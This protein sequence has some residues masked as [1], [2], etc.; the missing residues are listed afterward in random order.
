[1][2]KFTRSCRALP[3]I[4]LGA[5]AAMPAVAQQSNAAELEELRA[6]V[7]ALETERRTPLSFGAAGGT[8][9]NIYGFV[10][11]EFF[12]DPDFEFGDL[13]VAGDIPNENPDAQAF[14]SS[15]RVS[16]LGVRSSTPSA[17]GDI[18]TQLEYD[19]FGGEG[20]AELRL[21][22]ANVTIGD[23]LLFG[24]FWTNF[25][26]LS[27]YP[28]TADFNGP[29]GITFARVPQVRYS[30]ALGDLRYS[31][32][33]EESTAD[34]SNPAFT[35]AVSYDTDR[36]G[37]RAAVLG[38]SIDVDGEDETYGLYT[39]SGTA[40]LWQGGTLSATYVAGDAVGSLLIGGGDS[41]VGGELN[42]GEG[43]TVELRQEFG[44]FDVGIAYGHEEYDLAT[45]TSANSDFTE[46]DTIHLNAFYEPVDN[47]SIGVEYIYGERTDSS[48]NNFDASR[49][50]T[51]ITFSF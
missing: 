39:L 42:F 50:G 32:S 20:R 31:V 46:L 47:L 37:L 9:I 21:R 29:V 45:V 28:T 48:G 8:T 25:M 33:I 19:L 14:G 11:A 44:Q 5:M 7:A 30:N 4:A 41:V 12:Y 2:K 22:H 18:G 34:A 24:Q 35:G 51:S 15:V 13:F 38:S 49:I 3:V 43:Y 36:F 1:M 17:I 16:R 40:S 23:S 27:H 26:P 6:R 10:R